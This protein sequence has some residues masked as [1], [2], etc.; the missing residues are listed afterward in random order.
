MKET[1]SD[2]KNGNLIKNTTQPTE[3]KLSDGKWWKDNSATI[4]PHD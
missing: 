4:L 2:D 3:F 1:K